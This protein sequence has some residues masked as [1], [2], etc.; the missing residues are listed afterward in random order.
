VSSFWS[1]PGGDLIRVASISIWAL[2]QITNVFNASWDFQDTP[3]IKR[4]VHWLRKPAGAM[5]SLA[6]GLWKYIFNKT[7][8]HVL[9]LGVDKAGKTVSALKL[10]KRNR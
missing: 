7:E 9:I 3:T 2:L 1:D 4:Q 6:H 5:F 8:F 10:Y